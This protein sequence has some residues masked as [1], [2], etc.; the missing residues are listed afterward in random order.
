VYDAEHYFDGY[1]ED[2][3]YALATLRA[4]RDAGATTLVLCDTNGGMLTDDL[5]EIV[6]ATIA[7][8][9]SPRA[10]QGSADAA[11]PPVFGIH[12]H[13]DAGLAVANSLAAVARGVRHVQGTINGYGER[14]GNANL[15]TIWP[16]LALKLGLATVPGSDLRRLGE[17]SR[18][19]AEIAN[20]APDGHAPYVGASAFAHKGGVHGAATIRVRRSYQHVEPE[21]VGNETRLVVSELGG[22]ANAAWKAEQ[23]G[24]EL[25]GSID[26]ASLARLVKRLEADGASFE[27]AE[28]SFELLIQRARSEYRPP[29]RVIDFHVLVDRRDVAAVR[30]EAWVK[31]EVEGEPIH[32]AADGNGPVNAVDRALRRA[33][34]TFYPALAEV[35]LIDYKVRILDGDA[36]TAA[37]TRVVV[38]SQGPSGVWSTVGSDTNIIGASVEALLDSFEYALWKSDARPIARPGARTV[39]AVTPPAA[40]VSAA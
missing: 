19:V 28:A 33:L 12:V 13:D 29:F 25:E 32:A 3:A 2:R 24:H 8:F 20:I 14:C 9:A 16:N 38:E 40:D 34:E 4:A 18:F 6:S 7:A 11:A 35:H 10:G 31:V 15:V 39:A 22:R 23:L 30:S 21:L 27:G 26:A 17:L 5:A 1:R 36:A 37:R